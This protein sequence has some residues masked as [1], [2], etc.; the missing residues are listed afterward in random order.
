MCDTVVVWV[1]LLLASARS[2]GEPGDGEATARLRR[3]CDLPDG[4]LHCGDR[5]GR[6]GRADGLRDAAHQLHRPLHSPLRRRR[7]RRR[8]PAQDRIASMKT[9]SRFH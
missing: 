4:D 8:R 6:Q 3:P 7:Q 9:F 5:L 1:L 2:G